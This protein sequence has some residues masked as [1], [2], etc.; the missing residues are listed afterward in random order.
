MIHVDKVIDFSKKNNVKIALTLSDVNM[1]K[2]FRD[3]FESILKKGIDILFCNEEEALL[4]SGS[5]EIDQA[6]NYLLELSSLVIVTRGKKG[7]LIF[8]DDGE[9]IEIDPYPVDALD[10]VGAGDTFAGSFLYGINNN[11]SLKKSGDLASAMSSKVVSKLGPRLEKKDVRLIKQ[12][13][14]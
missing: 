14:G 1:V 4:Y 9:K 11:L 8:S 5:N 12:S 3:S 6:L 2:Y 10:T 7:S 13:I